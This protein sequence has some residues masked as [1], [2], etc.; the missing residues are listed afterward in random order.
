MNENKMSTP[1]ETGNATTVNAVSSKP[2]R[3]VANYDRGRKT[4]ITWTESATVTVTD[5]GLVAGLEPSTLY[6]YIE[7]REEKIVDSEGT[8]LAEVEYHDDKDSGDEEEDGELT[9]FD[10]C[11]VGYEETGEE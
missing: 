8:V 2:K 6:E 11:D 10:L 4:I 3:W 9:Q 1:N 7:N 5:A